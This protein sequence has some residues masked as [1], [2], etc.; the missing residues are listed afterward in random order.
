MLNTEIDWE[1][2]KK[3]KQDVMELTNEY[4]LAHLRQIRIKES[5]VEIQ[6]RC[7]HIFQKRG[8]YMSPS[9]MVCLWCDKEKQ[10]R[11]N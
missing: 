10:S 7:I 5:I 1:T 2:Q 4:S 8:M 9:I 6:N 11:K 3:I